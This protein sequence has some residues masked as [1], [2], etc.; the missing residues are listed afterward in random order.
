MSESF[1][2]YTQ[3]GDNGLVYINKGEAAIVSIPDSDI[4]TQNLIDY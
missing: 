4:E 2:E 3:E 1:Y